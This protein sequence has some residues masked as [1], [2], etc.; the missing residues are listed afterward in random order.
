[1][2][3]ADDNYNYNANESARWLRHPQRSKTIDEENLLFGRAIFV[4]E[5][6]FSLKYVCHFRNGGFF[7]R[8]DAWCVC[9]HCNNNGLCNRQKGV[10][11]ESVWLRRDRFAARH[12]T[13]NW[14]KLILVHSRRLTRIQYTRLP[15]PENPSSSTQS[16]TPIAVIVTLSTHYHVRHQRIKTTQKRKIKESCHLLLPKKGFL[17]I[18]T[19]RIHWRLI[20]LKNKWNVKSGTRFCWQNE[21][22]MTTMSTISRRFEIW[23]NANRGRAAVHLPCFDR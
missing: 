13:E 17:Y 4:A 7:V 22:S 21:W 14:V 16:H 12:R 6:D 18:F 5:I 8:C 1:M 10:L 11:L 15:R 20:E 2:R 9:V 19:T 23:A 3:W